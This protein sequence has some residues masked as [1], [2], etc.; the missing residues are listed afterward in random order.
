MCRITIRRNAKAYFR[1]LSKY[2]AE[3][4]QQRETWLVRW[5]VRNRARLASRSTAE[6]ERIMDQR[7]GD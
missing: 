3:S 1:K 2:I 5:R 7:E 4:A 6:R